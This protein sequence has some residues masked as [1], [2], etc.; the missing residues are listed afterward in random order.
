[1][2][3]FQRKLLDKL[4]ETLEHQVRFGPSE[5]A[6]MRMLDYIHEIRMS[7]RDSLSAEDQAAYDAQKSW[8][9]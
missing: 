5:S 7:Y 6:Q 2:N 9:D 3:E 1:M 4:E 8:Y